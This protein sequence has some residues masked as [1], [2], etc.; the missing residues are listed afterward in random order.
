MTTITLDGIIGW[1][2]TAAEVRAALAESGNEISLHINSPG[3]DV[4]EGV[5]ITNALR[6]Y[7]REG[8][9][10]H[11]RITGIA[12]SMG[13]YIAMFT[14]RLEVEDNAILMVHNPWTLAMGDYRAME[15]AA[16]ILGSL[17]AMLARAYGHRTGKK[18]DA[19]LAEMDDETWYYGDEIVSAG[20]AD[21]LIPAGDGPASRTEAL[22][23][24][25]SSYAAMRAKIREREADTARLDQIAALLPQPAAPSA[26]PPQETPMADPKDA[27]GNPEAAD[28]ATPDLTTVVTEAVQAAVAAERQRIADITRVCASVRL[29]DRA[30]AWIEEGISIDQAR[31]RLIDLIAAQGGPEMRNAPAPVASDDFDALVQAAMA[32]GK[33]RAQAMRAV[34]TAHPEQHRAWLARV[35]AA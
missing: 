4:H 15:K 24:A 27:A 19:V 22:A 11:A 8:G 7:R 26:S 1:D 35:N 25:Q 5:A 20:Y 31:A 32:S 12:A 33:S 3:G 18:D 2:I 23:L 17:R 6:Q 9:R 34:I 10:V 28:P 14:D 13:S 29:P 16:S 30:Q 21:A